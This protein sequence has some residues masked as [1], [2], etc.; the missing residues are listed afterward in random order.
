MLGIVSVDDG[1]KKAKDL[2]LDLVEISP[3]TKPP[4]CKILDLGKYRYR[5]QKKQ[6]QMKKKQKISVTK[7]VRFRPGIDD[8]DYQ[9]K[10]KHIQKFL[11]K[12]DKVKFTVRFKG[13]EMQHTHLGNKLMDRIINDTLKFGKIEV[14]PKFEGKQM[15]MIIQPL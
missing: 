15:I 4:I 1:I 5:Q 2:G 14:N 9:I 11:Q 12:G 8:H 7:E 13:R 3:N 6:S 10:M